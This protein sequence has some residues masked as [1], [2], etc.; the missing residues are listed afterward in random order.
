MGDI[1][2][3]YLGISYN[4]MA[5]WKTICDRASGRKKSCD[6]LGYEGMSVMFPAK[7]S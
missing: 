4:N 6:M 3:K 2:I 7:L 5:I 1:Y